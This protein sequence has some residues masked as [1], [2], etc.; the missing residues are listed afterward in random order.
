MRLP[1]LRP[2][3]PT[4]FRSCFAALGAV[5]LLATP[6]WAEELAGPFQ[7]EVLR[8]IDGDTFVGRV[9]VWLG[10]FQTTRVRLRGF[11]APELP[12]AAGTAARDRLAAVIGGGNVW[13]SGVRP[14]KYGG[15]VDAFVRLSTGEDVIPLLKE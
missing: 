9:H 5:C 10:L 2:A 14:D 6:A 13:L 8:I 11:N 3:V 7:A 12:G 4:M 15:R 1:G